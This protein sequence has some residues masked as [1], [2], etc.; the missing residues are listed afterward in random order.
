MKKENYLILYTMTASELVFIFKI[1]Q[2]VRIHGR[3][4]GVWWGPDPSPSK[5]LYKWKINFFRSSPFLVIHSCGIRINKKFNN[6]RIRTKKIWTPLKKFLGT[7]LYESIKIREPQAYSVTGAY[8]RRSFVGQPLFFGK[9][10]Q[11]AR[12]FKE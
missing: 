9:Y 6:L 4:Q 5:F 11:S 12:I 10:F 1:L 7:P 2:K 3:N 8:S